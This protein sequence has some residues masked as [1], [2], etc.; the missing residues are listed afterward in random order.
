MLIG[1][2]SSAPERKTFDGRLR[3]PLAGAVH[4]VDSGELELNPTHLISHEVIYRSTK[5]QG[6]AINPPIMQLRRLLDLFTE[7]L[8]RSWSEFPNFVSIAA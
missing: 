6:T 1:V 2:N 4:S 8:Q 5:T 3:I 7:P